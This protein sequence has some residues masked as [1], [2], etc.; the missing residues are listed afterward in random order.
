[1]GVEDLPGRQAQQVWLEIQATLESKAPRVI[2][3]FQASRVTQVTL[4]PP[5]P[6]GPQGYKGSEGS[7]AL[8]VLAHPTRAS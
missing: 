5:G 4:D 1:M 8:Q 2:Q 7:E 3:G 6:Q